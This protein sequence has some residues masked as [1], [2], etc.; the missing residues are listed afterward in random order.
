MNRE[1]RDLPRQHCIPWLCH[2][3]TARIF[4]DELARILVLCFLPVPC[5]HKHYE[6]G[7]LSHVAGRA[8]YVDDGLDGI[9]MLSTC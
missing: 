5:V 7:E 4:A 1:V 2:S 3:P 6:A 8:Y 9:I